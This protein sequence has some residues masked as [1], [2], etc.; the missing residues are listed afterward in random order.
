MLRLLKPRINL[1]F[2]ANPFYIYGISFLLVIVV[3]LIGWSKIFPHLS[4]GLILFFTLTSAIFFSI[5]K[6][7]ESRREGILNK[8]QE[9]SPLYIDL[10]FWL[11]ILLGI[12]DV[13]YMGYIPILDRS[14]NYREFGMPV[15]DIL[16]IP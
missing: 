7:F 5:G 13:T 11:I 8:N 2:L 3:Y 10:V 16:F 1:I 4:A 14:H 15:I 6:Y 12:I 9:L